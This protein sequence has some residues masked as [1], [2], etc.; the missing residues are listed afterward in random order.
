MSCSATL[1]ASGGIRPTR[2][3]RFASLATMRWKRIAE[4]ASA[5]GQRDQLA[6]VLD[7][8][9]EG[10]TLLVARLDRLARSTAELAGTVARS[11]LKTFATARVATTTA[12][13][14]GTAT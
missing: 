4:Q 2:R 9:R 8:V 3:C 12:S 14:P 11:F 10:D 13:P 1:A 5:V 6:A 7:F